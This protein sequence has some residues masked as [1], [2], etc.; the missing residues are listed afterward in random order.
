MLRARITV[1]FSARA[2][3][4]CTAQP[5]SLWHSSAHCPETSYCWWELGWPRGLGWREAVHWVGGRG[6]S[7]TTV[8]WG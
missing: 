2:G 8:C 5:S 7:V 6:I 1:P 3:G 4:G